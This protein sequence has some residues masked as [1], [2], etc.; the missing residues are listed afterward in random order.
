M[1][2]LFSSIHRQMDV[3]LNA[4]GQVMVDLHVSVMLATVFV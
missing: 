1:N 2:I 4:S 3:E